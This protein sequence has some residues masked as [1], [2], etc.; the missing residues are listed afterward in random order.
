MTTI[1]VT[2]VDAARDVVFGEA[3]L[4]AER[5]PESFAAA[6]TLHLGDSEWQVERAEPAER[7]DFVATGRLRLVLSK[8]EWVDPQTILFSLP[9]IE[10]TM[11]PLVDDDVTGAFAMHED[12]WRQRELV[13]TAFAPEIV[14]E[15]AAIQAL[16]A[17]QTGAGFATLHV[18][19]RL[20]TPLHGQHLALAD[21]EAAL[22][23]P[24]RRDLTVGGQRVAGGFALESAGAR[25]YGYEHEG[26]VAALG[27]VDGLPPALAELARARGLVLVDWCAA[28]V[29]GELVN[30]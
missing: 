4:P 23:R 20:P 13:S 2:F 12:D 18:R 5:L 25:V 30:P 6:T 10:N 9:T 27:V 11:P 21:V 17:A 26:R 7:R 1:R 29:T 19:E 14:A 8:I 24:A 15:L 3:D 16:L 28:T 22:G